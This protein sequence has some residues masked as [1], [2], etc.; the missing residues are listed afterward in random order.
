MNSEASDYGLA[1]L[2]VAACTALCAA[3]FGRLELTNLVMIYL[4]G[5]TLVASRGR[6]GPA[7]LFSALAVL[8]FDYFFV[9]PRLSFAVSDTEYFVTFF[10]MLAVSLTIS[11][12]AV[13]LREKADAAHALAQRT[14]ALHDLSR[15]LAGT[16]GLQ[17]TIESGVAHLA[18]VFECD[19]RAVVP[20]ADGRLPREL[21]EKAH[22]VA[23]WVLKSGLPAG[24]GTRALPDA[25][26]L[27]APLIGLS[28]P[29]GILRV[30]ARAE[31]KPL[32]ED[33]TALLES[34]SRQIALALEA[35]R[36]QDEARRA[37]RETDAE[38]V[39][40]ALLSSVSH[41]LRTP[42]AA[43]IGSASAMLRPGS[44]LPKRMRELA[45]DIAGE[46][47]RLARLVNNL[48]D[49]TKLEAGNVSLRL[50]PVAIEELV[51]SAL[52][53]TAPAL[54]GR[55]ISTAIPAKIPLIA[56]DAPLI[57]QLIVNLLENVARHTPRG[58]P[59]AVQARA[60][61]GQLEV[62]VAD[63]G[64]GLSAADAKRVF[65]KFY[66]VSGAKAGGAGLGLTICRGIVAAHGG[67]I[68]ASARPGGGEI[69]TFALPYER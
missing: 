69:F 39:R 63:R 36:L 68:R 29:V 35:D 31:R 23:S 62:S 26:A 18:S 6:R 11:G 38:R 14:S 33:E 13:R 27:Y 3:L 4:V 32:S 51:G 48:L 61:S 59:L 7:V 45:A 21:D 60:R 37:H 24:P 8:S 56:V 52:E 57:E 2:A 64:P 54:K 9:P 58:T 16:R 42:L 1:V 44:R 67:K 19:V 55:K 49:A 22:G 43:I 30:A 46:G 50:E 5:A 40:N 12:L 25:D 20:D 17:Q 10:V 28:G 65:E 15:R 47:E 66:R 53:R 41:D 34:F